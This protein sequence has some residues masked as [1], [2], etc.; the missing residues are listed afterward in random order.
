MGPTARQN[1]A[2][3]ASAQIA[4]A[5]LSNP[6]ADPTPVRPFTI[7]MP[8]F[9]GRAGIAAF[10]LSRFH[11]V[12]LLLVVVNHLTSHRTSTRPLTVGSLYYV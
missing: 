6:M 5:N 1:W 10:T 3:W 4:I 7:C 11:A 8:A 9:L 2:W 12:T